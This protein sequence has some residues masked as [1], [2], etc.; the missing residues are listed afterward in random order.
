MQRI[1]LARSLYVES[2]ILILDEA[3][4]S[5]DKNNEK[6]LIENINTIL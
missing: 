3:T 5:L 2:Q 1:G 4:N 6:I